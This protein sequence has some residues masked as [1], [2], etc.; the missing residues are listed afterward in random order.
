M[1]ANSSPTL[2]WSERM[3][4]LGGDRR[5]SLALNLAVR[6]RGQEVRDRVRVPQAIAQSNKY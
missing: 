4:H 6:S 1:Q 5:L 3:K 2:H